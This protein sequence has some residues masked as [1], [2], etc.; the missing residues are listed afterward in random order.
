M[1]TDTH[2]PTTRTR[3]AR[4]ASMGAVAGV[5]ASLMMAAYAM[6]A[7]ATYQG[8][9]FFTP[10]YHIASTFISPDDMMSSMEGAMGGSNFEFYF[11]PALLGALI[12]MMVGAM[13]GVGFGVLAN[14][15]RIHEMALVAAAVLWGGLVFVISSFVGLPL[16]AAIFDSGDQ[17]TNMAELVGYGTFLIEHLIF[18]LFLGLILFM[19]AKRARRTP[20]A[21]T[22]EDQT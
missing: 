2:A 18:G 20:S 11:G 22:S 3:F 15:T 7:A 12:H 21:P 9:G 19:G 8:S 10:L 4:A 13:Y 16:A 5:I 14:L 17:I 6:I 1:S